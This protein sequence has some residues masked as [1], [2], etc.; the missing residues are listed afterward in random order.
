MS[1]VYEMK[2][3]TITVLAKILNIIISIATFVKSTALK[4]SQYIQQEEV[5]NHW[6]EKNI[7]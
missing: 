5:D 7:D 6:S 2:Q 3:T 4:A 1:N